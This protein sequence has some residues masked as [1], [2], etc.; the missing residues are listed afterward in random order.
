M[1]NHKNTVRWGL[2]LL[3]F[4]TSI[5]RCVATGEQMPDN[6]AQYVSFKKMRSKSRT[7]LRKHVRELLAL[8]AGAAIA[9]ATTAYV[10]KRRSKR[11]VK[12]LLQLHQTAVE[13]LN[14]AHSNA[15]AHAQETYGKEVAELRTSF[16]A[17]V[18]RA[19]DS[20]S[21]KQIELQKLIHAMLSEQKETIKE[22]VAAFKA[23]GSNQFAQT[24]AALQ[25]QQEE[26]KRHWSQQ[27]KAL[28]ES[29]FQLLH[30][31]ADR[32]QTQYQEVLAKIT[33]AQQEAR[34]AQSEFAAQQND[35]LEKQKEVLREECRKA[36]AGLDARHAQ[37]EE[38]LEQAMEANNK[39]NRQQQEE[40]VSNLSAYAKEL[41]HYQAHNYAQYQQSLEALQQM[42]GRQQQTTSKV[43]PSSSVSV[44]SRSTRSKASSVT[45]GFTGRSPIRAF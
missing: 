1:N 16:D 15:L 40:L 37:V 43:L 22:G 23:E 30:E 34:S 42:I 28:Q 12:E 2:L 45:S 36:L 31:H 21:A 14:D 41:V 17:A 26:N 11:E 7:F 24:H 20:F 9:S 25:Q 29:V 38:L 3:I 5:E 10:Q 8:L 19:F 27:I 32:I 39:A 18:A 4:T 35:L 13:S 33:Q 44:D 6:Y